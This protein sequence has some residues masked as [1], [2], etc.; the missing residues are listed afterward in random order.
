M[1]EHDPRQELM[2]TQQNFL[3][4]DECELNRE[5]EEN[6]AILS[7][8]SQWEQVGEWVP[9]QQIQQALEREREREGKNA[10]KLVALQEFNEELLS[11]AKEQHQQ[12]DAHAQ[13]SSTESESEA[14]EQERIRPKTE[15]A[16]AGV[17][18]ISWQCAALVRE[19]VFNTV[20][21]TVIVRR[22]AAA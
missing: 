1:A 3:E 16:S 9:H 12:L 2:A 21:G 6:V 7:Q 14:E 15:T 10:S 5:I 18:N 13:P 22:G 11:V 4:E 20:P 8:L 17:A 19:A